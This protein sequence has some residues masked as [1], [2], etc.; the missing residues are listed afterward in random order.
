MENIITFFGSI[1]DEERGRYMQ[2][3]LYENGISACIEKVN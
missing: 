2:K 3:D 1:G